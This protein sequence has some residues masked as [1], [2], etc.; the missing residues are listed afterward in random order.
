MLH[1]T[2]RW[3]RRPEMDLLKYAAI[4]NRKTFP[5]IALP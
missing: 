5:N 3:V 1:R 2:Y 4:V